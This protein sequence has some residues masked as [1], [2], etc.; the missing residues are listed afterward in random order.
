MLKIKANSECSQSID[1]EQYIHRHVYT[2]NIVEVLVNHP[3]AKKAATVDG[4]RHWQ[5]KYV[6]AFRQAHTK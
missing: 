2:V 1:G 3:Q 6:L 5:G 4:R